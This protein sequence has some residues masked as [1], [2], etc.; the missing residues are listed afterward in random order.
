MMVLTV[1]QRSERVLGVNGN[2]LP[3]SLATLHA[4][5]SNLFV[6][7]M[8]QTYI[9]QCKATKDLDRLNLSNMGRSICKSVFALSFVESHSRLSDIKQINGIVVTRI[10]SEIVVKIGTLPSLGD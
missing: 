5:V 6:S 7:A 1:D 8:Y 2:D 10:S 4:S 3:V 9:I